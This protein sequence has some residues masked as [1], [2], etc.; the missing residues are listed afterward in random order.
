MVLTMAEAGWKQIIPPAPTLAD[1]LVLLLNLVPIAISAVL[2]A[3][4]WMMEVNM[5]K[6][7]LALPLVCSFVRLN[8]TYDTVRQCCCAP[9]RAS[10]FSTV[11]DIAPLTCTRVPY[12]LWG[13]SWLAVLQPCPGGSVGPLPV[14]QNR[15]RKRDK[16]PGQIGRHHACHC[17]KT[18]ATLPSCG[19]TGLYRA[20]CGCCKPTCRLESARGHL[21]GRFQCCP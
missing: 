6:A 20:H 10:S 9:V 14:S 13:H 15:R 16:G 19:S 8:C 3:I 7:Q 18:C 1:R 12:L 17:R 4:L 11:V 5:G 21:P 2:R